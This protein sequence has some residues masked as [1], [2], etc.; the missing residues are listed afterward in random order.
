MRVARWGNS[1]AVRL[2]KAVA[3]QAQFQEGAEADVAVSVG[4]ITIQRRP[5]MNGLDELVDQIT[6]SNRHDETGWGEPQGSE[7][8]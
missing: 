6:P 1:L 5:T 8:W 2:P 4:R 7:M 3:E